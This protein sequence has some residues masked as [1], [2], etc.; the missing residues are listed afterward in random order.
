MTDEMAPRRIGSTVREE[1]LAQAGL[2]A[3]E[4][5]AI[6]IYRLQSLLELQAEGLLP[7]RLTRRENLREAILR[8]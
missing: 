1:M 8:G 5:N 6:Q 4:L 2:R 7:L 3:D